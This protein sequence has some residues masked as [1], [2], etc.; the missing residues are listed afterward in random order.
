VQTA[1][2]VLDRKLGWLFA[3]AVVA[4]YQPRER[5]LTYAC[6]GHPPPIVLG[7]ESLA[8]VTVCS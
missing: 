7:S 4:T 2:V 1:V 8:A 6:A 3:T 5:I